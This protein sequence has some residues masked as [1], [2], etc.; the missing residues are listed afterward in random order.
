MFYPEEFKSKVTK[1]CLSADKRLQEE[2]QQ[3]L[4]D[5]DTY[6]GNLLS[7]GFSTTF[8]F[9]EILEANSLE[10][11]QI[12]AKEMQKFYLLSLEWRKLYKE[13]NLF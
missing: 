6:L 8:S 4:T 2:V 13:Q 1:A 11:L 5:G 10:E 9:Q 12:K 3:M 7:Y